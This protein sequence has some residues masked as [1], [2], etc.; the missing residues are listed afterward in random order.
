MTD[1]FSRFHPVVNI[2][3]YMV[4]LI[5]TMFQMQQVMVIISTVCAIIYHIYLK[6]QKSVKFCIMAFFIF[7][8]SAV[9]N[10]LFSH[11]GATLLFYM[12]TGN[13]VTLESIVYG[14]FA[15]LVIVAMIFWLST[16]NE[17][18]TEDKIL[19]L[20][21]AIMPSVA[22]LLTMIFRFVSKFTKK[23]KEISMTHK[24]L[25]GEPEGFFNKIKSSLHIFSITITWAL[26][27]SVDTADSM[28]AR[29]YGCAKRTNYNNYRIEKRDILLSLWMIMLF[30]VVISRWDSGDLYTYYYPFVRTKGQIMV[31][32][33]Y[34]LL[35][36]TPMAV[37]ILEGIRWRRLKSKI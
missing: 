21:G 8:A 37:N 19:A 26:E 24:A 35:C 32:V 9:I 30:G 20:I 17:I 5:I 3:F 22:L 31:Y 34:I 2:I 6:K 36:V 14:V 28:T 25:K 10:P 11:K 18:M 16:F 23:I 4:V 13:P 1:E 12:F 29:G 33:A 15:A 7:T 27:N